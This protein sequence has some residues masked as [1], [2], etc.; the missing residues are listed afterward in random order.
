MC[1]CVCVCVCVCMQYFG[2]KSFTIVG[3]KKN[4]KFQVCSVQLMTTAS[5]AC[6][7]P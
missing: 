6:Y 1:V 7:C 3:F 4:R 5:W 2:W